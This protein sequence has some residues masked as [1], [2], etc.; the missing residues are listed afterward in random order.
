MKRHISRGAVDNAG[1]FLSTA[2]AIHCVTVPM[3]VTFLPLL[4]LGFLA[5]EPAEFAIVGAVLLAAVLAMGV[6]A[7]GYM[8]AEGGLEVILHV[9]GG[10][11]LAATHLLNRHLCRTCT[12]AE[13]GPT[14]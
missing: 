8:A 7:A 9:T 5:S 11:L 10:V 1:V 14:S 2:C 3:L 12:A 4:G 13:C 6:I